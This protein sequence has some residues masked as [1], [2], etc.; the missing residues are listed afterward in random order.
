MARSAELVVMLCG[1]DASEHMME[2]VFGG[3][4]REHSAAGPLNRSS[5]SGLGL[6]VS[7]IVRR[8]AP[9]LA[10]AGMGTSPMRSSV[11][12]GGGLAGGYGP[13]RAGGSFS[14]RLQSGFLSLL[15]SKDRPEHLGGL[16]GN[17]QSREGSFSS[18]AS[19]QAVPY[20][21]T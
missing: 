20:R 3:H 16:G 8:L 4:L 9:P 6:A 12:V 2:L 14:S 10:R 11:S 15:S 1:M 5:S 7:N 18:L 13:H 17:V 21:R 19:S